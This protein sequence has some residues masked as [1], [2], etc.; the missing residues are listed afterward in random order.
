MGLKNGQ[1]QWI[2]N[3]ESRQHVHFLRACHDAVLVGRNT[4]EI[5]DPMLNIRHPDF[6]QKANK[7]VIFDSEGNLFSNL[8]SRKVASCHNAKDIF[9]VTKAGIKPPKSDYQHIECERV[10]EFMFDLKDLLKKLFQIGIGSVMVEGGSMTY[11][12]FFLQKQAQRVIH[13]QAP[14]LLGHENGLPWTQ[15]LEIKSMNE[16]I[17]LKDVRARFF[18]E[19]LMTTARLQ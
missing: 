13:F 11:K 7:V 18:K 15:G 1:S 10:G 3:E 12:S 9:I 6:P 14:I 4:I 19:D 17:V 8:Q 2:T 5:D 16:R